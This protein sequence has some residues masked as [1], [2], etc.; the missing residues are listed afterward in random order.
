MPRQRSQS[1]VSGNRGRGL[2]WRIAGNVFWLSLFTLLLL[3]AK[4]TFDVTTPGKLLEGAVYAWLQA[5]LRTDENVQVAVVDISELDAWPVIGRPSPRAQLQSLIDAVAAQKP[6]AIGIDVDF[7]PGDEGWPAR[8]GPQFFDHLRDLSTRVYVGADRT[9]Y[10]MPA[11][12]LGAAEYEDL[13]VALAIPAEDSRMMPLWIGRGDPTVCLNRIADLVGLAASQRA[14]SDQSSC[15]LSMSAAL[16]LQFHN[17]KAHSVYLPNWFAQPI[18]ITTVNKAQ[19]ISTASFLA[20]Y[21]AVNSL[22]EHTSQ[23]I[24]SGTDVILKVNPALTGLTNKIVILGYTRW[25]T[26]PD[27][28]YMLP[29]QREVPGVYFHASGVHTL[30]KGPLLEITSVG[31]AFLDVIFVAF[32]AL[33]LSLLERRGQ[34]IGKFVAVDRMRFVIIWTAIFAAAILELCLVPLTRILWTDWLLVCV[35]LLIHGW[36]DRHAE[37]HGTRVK[38]FLKS[39]VYDSK[40]G[41]TA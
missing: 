38:D 16:A 3:L 15:L 30:I 37:R 17:L 22:R 14:A 1:A 20:D 4:L 32:V 5:Q 41:R 18:E 11:A 31:R 36:L 9:R 2:G 27:K 26:T 12:W 28:Y 21:G 40:K 13:A 23:A 29:W 6:D 19:Q 33:C 25:E 35:V 39:L 8:G 24:V 7:S 34:R 10:G